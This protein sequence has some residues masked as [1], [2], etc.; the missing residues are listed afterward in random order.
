M[1]LKTFS[2]HIN[3]HDGIETDFNTMLCSYIDNLLLN[4]WKMILSLIVY[5]EAFSKIVDAKRYKKTLTFVKR[6]TVNV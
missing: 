3:E 6:E 5:D 1:Q 2:F 4:G